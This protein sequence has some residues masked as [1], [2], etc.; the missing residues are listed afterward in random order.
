MTL[1]LELA[2]KAFI[3]YWNTVDVQEYVGC[4]QS[5]L[6]FAYLRKCSPQYI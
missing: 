1:I 6:I 2:D 3:L 5:D 4:D